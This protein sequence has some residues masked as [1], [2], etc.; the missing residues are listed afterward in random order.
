[1]ANRSKLS[2]K[3]LVVFSLLTVA[4]LQGC[5]GPAT[6]SNRQLAASTGTCS[7]PNSAVPEYF[8]LINK[9]KPEFV[10]MIR[11]FPKGGDIHNHLSGA[12]MPEDYIDMGMQESDCYGPAADDPTQYAIKLNNGEPGACGP[13]DQPLSLLGARDRQKLMQSLSMYQFSYA[14]IQAGHDQFFATF[15]RF[16]AVSGADGVKGKMLAKMLQQANTDSVSYVETMMSFQS[17][18]VNTL[19]DRLRQ[20]YPDPSFYTDSRN[21]PAMFD[22]LQSVGL[23]NAVTAAQDDISSQVRQMQETLGCGTPSRDPA[24]GVSCNFLSAANRNAAMHGNVDPAKI[25]AQTVFS[26]ALADRDPRVVGVNLV[27]GED[28]PVSMQNFTTEMQF[29]SFCHGIFPEVNIALHGGEITPCFVGAGNPALKDHLAG[30]IQAGAKRLGH[31]ISFEYLN[32]GQQAEVVNLMKSNDTLVEILFTSNAQILGVTGDG[33]PFPQYY[34]KYDI[35]VALS[36]DDEGVSHSDYTTEWLYAI[37]K[38]GLSYDDVVRLARFSLQYS[39]LPGDPLWADVA[40]AKAAAPCAAEEPGR[41]VARESAC[42]SFLQNSTKARA[43]WDYEARLADFN[44]NY[45]G[46]FRQYLGQLQ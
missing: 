12:I 3:I 32:D 37:I 24:C 33:H 21:Y 26:F 31:G 23:Q 44:R 4:V 29:F 6:E 16:G 13:G 40:K 25:F 28:L 15:G 9:A 11:R 34:R 35:P 30:S 17:G 2:G 42:E 45:G 8:D 46:K 36:T 22:L 27:S 19:A 43:Q 1:M 20:L 7:Q 14:D 10:Q 41:I 39:F 38:Y 5:A 18:A